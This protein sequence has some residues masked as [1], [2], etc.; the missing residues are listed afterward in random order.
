MVIGRPVPTLE[1][2]CE[3]GRVQTL[4]EVVFI[5]GRSGIGKTSVAAEIIRQLA[6]ARIQH[7][8]IEGD[9]LGQA[10][11]EPWRRG[12]PLVEQNVAAMWS[13]YRAIGYH[14]LIYTNT[15]SD[16]EMDKLSEALGEVGRRIGVLLTGSDEVAARRLKWREIGSGLDQHVQRS[17]DAARE[18]ESTAPSYVHR[19]PTDHSPVE[20]I[21]ATIIHLTEW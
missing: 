17:N 8:L 16:L 2:Q 21:A 1:R 4:T 5:G 15:G 13:N 14:R 7:A 9:N 10:Y 20:V 6:A 19:V 11:P 3:D 18:L 12:I